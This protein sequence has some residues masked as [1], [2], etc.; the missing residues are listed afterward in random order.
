MKTKSVVVII[1][2]G[3]LTQCYG[4]NS[5]GKSNI[6]TSVNY[7]ILGEGDYSAVH[8]ENGFSYSIKPVFQV[9]AALGF[10]CSSNDGSENILLSHN[11]S[12]IS[13]DLLVKILPVRSKVFNL[14]FGFGYSNRYR[15]EIELKDL[16]ITNEG[17]KLNY[18]NEVSFDIGYVCQIEL[19]FRV[20]P[21]LMILLNGEMHEYKNGTG[22]ASLGM[23]LNIKL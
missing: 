10:I 7:A 12:Y 5:D 13:G 19:G 15:S 17:T 14:F 23:G 22:V 20:S 1:L 21:K 2:L 11:N 4:Q 18:S 8:I 16:L 3:I 9:A 6:N